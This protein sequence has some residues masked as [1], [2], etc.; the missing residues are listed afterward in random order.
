MSSYYAK[1]R[2]ES[3]RDRN[4]LNRQRAGSMERRVATFFSGMRVPS[5]GASWMKG[6]ARIK[7]NKYGIIFVECKLS[8]ILH[9]SLGPVIKFQNSWITKTEKDARSMLCVFGVVIFRYHGHNGVGYVAVARDLYTK[10]AEGAETVLIDL[11]YPKASFTLPKNK[12]DA[13]LQTGAR[14]KLVIQSGEYV[15]ITAEEFKQFLGEEE[16]EEDVGISS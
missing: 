13:I 7:S 16:I 11:V 6:D 12:L 8:S 3:T 9:H 2:I 4:K 1:K 15:I 10:L 14:P 5:S